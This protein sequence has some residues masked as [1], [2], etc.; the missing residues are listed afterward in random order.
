MIA[1][2]LD[3]EDNKA[4]QKPKRAGLSLN[5]IVKVGRYH[6]GVQMV[7]QN[8]RRSTKSHSLR[9][10][11]EVPQ[12]ILICCLGP[13][14][15]HDGVEQGWEIKHGHWQRWVHALPGH[16]AI[17]LDHDEQP[18]VNTCNASWGRGDQLSIDP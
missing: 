4:V 3:E 5:N 2:P 7:S 13:G 12:A 10:P 15:I 16:V 9:Q 1:C 6:K 14:L 17:R 8:C 18:A 11:T